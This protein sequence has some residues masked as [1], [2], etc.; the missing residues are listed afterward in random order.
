[1]HDT[2]GSGILTMQDP[3]FLVRRAFEFGVNLRSSFHAY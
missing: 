3:C 2:T 1:M